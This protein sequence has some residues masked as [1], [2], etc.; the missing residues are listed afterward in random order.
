MKGLTVLSLALALGCAEVPPPE[1]QRVAAARPEPSLHLVDDRNWRLFEVRRS[2]SER[3]IEFREEA[4]MEQPT[5]LEWKGGVTRWLDPNSV[6]VLPR[7]YLRNRHSAEYRFRHPWTGVEWVV[8][9][10]A[11]SRRVALISA[12]IDGAETARF[13][14]RRRSGQEVTYRLAIRRAASEVDRN[15]SLGI[16]LAF[17]RMRE[18][19]LGLKRADFR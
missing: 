17:D 3:R 15:L 13:L 16:F 1:V 2:T 9:G 14:Q 11:L 18:F 12:P 10:R 7:V 4:P 5:V 8:E 6:L 19:V